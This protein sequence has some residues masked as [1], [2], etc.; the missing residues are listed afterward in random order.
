VAKTLV[1]IE[2]GAAAFAGPIADA[3]KGGKLKAAKRGVNAFLGSVL[4]SPRPTA[5]SAERT[6]HGPGRE[7]GA[8]IGAG[9]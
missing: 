5:P 9:P 7:P 1:K 2:K 6:W 4:N 8:I 3:E